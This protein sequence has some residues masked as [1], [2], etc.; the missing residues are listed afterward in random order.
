MII[1]CG[2][3][4]IIT[5]AMLVWS[6]SLEMAIMIQVTYGTYIATEVAYYT[7]IYAK[8]DK[9]HYLKVTSHTRAAILSGKF[10]SGVSAQTLVYTQWMDLRQL[11][12]LTLIGQTLATIW[13]FFLPSVNRSMYFNRESMTSIASPQTAGE[14]EFGSSE[15]NDT[16]ITQQDIVPRGKC[17]AAFELI[18]S[19]LKASYSNRDVQLWSF[20]YAAGMCG[21]LQVLSYIQMLWIDIDNRPEVIWNGAV[22]AITTLL[23]ASVA[24]LASRIHENALNLRRMLWLIVTLSLLQACGIFVASN[25][26]SRFVSYAGYMAYYIFYTFTITISRLVESQ[27]LVTGQDKIHSLTYYFSSHSI[28]A[29]IA[30]HL[31]EDSYGLIFGINTFLALILQTLLVLVVVTDNFGLKLNISEQFD[32]YTYFYIVLGVIYLIPLA[33]D[34]LSTRKKPRNANQKAVFIEAT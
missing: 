23:S 3:S 33:H 5:Y 28:S 20:W 18:Y 15:L 11:N 31:P 7:Y 8:V 2:I 26:T 6:T 1:V 19:Q 21:H 10:I 12:V 25:T 29:E 9:A 22:E 27:Y 14:A 17:G 13:A 34:A 32:V 16:T 4:G 30:K 24:L